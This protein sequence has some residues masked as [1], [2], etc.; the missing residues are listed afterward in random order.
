MLGD[1]YKV[2]NFGATGST[3]LLNSWKPYMD[4]PQFENA[5]A[6]EPKI[7]VIMLGQ[8]MTLR[9]LNRTMKVSKRITP[10]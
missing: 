5:E 1:N 8:T 6:F 4:Q 10:H 7:V 2:G 9:G 3:V